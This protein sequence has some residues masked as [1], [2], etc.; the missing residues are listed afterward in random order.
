MLDRNTILTAAATDDRVAVEVPVWG[1]TVYLRPLTLAQVRHASAAAE[2]AGLEEATP[3][4]LARHVEQEDGSRIF[5]DDDAAALEAMPLRTLK[6][7]VTAL[8][9]IN[10]FDETAEALAGKSAPTVA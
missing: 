1:G 3:M 2:A 4:L 6:P 5:H 9:R 7:L 10:G 8:N